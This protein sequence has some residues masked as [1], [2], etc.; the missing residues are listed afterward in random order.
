MAKSELDTSRTYQLDFTFGGNNYHVEIAVGHLPKFLPNNGASFCAPGVTLPEQLDQSLEVEYFHIEDE[1][2][3]SLPGRENSVGVPIREAASMAFALSATRSIPA[4]VDIGGGVWLCFRR[5]AQTDDDGYFNV[6][7]QRSIHADTAD[8]QPS[9]VE[10][11][12]DI[13]SNI[14]FPRAISFTP[15]SVQ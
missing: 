5:A 15:W 1:P 14:Q 7:V 11:F 2:T 12:K 8:T 3:E 13:L 4:E 9:R 6:C 10:A